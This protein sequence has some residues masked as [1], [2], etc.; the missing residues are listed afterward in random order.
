MASELP[1]FRFTVQDWQNGKISLE[2]LEIQGIFISI[3]GYYW[4]NDCSITLTNLLK[5]YRNE[6]NLI[7]ELI[8]LGI[9]KHEKRHDKV[10]IEFLNLQFDLLSEKRKARRDAGSRGGKAKAMLKQK[11]SYKDK[12]NN[13]DNNKDKDNIE[14]PFSFKKSLSVFCSNENLINEWLLVR[15]NKKATNTETAFN[16]FKNEVEKSGKSFD[17]VLT[18]CVEKSWSGFK[19]EWITKIESKPD[20]QK[21]KFEKIIENRNTAHD[22]ISKH[23]ASNTETH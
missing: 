14:A 6:S 21:T 11:S 17:E 9:I 18:V 1:Y 4:I 7:S 20:E 13:K 5:K 19:S 8:N 2:S 15:K 23:Y 10:E 22:L 12:D 16:L 3:C